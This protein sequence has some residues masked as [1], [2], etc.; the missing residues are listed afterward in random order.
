MSATSNISVQEFIHGLDDIK[1]AE[2]VMKR[3]KEDDDPQTAQYGKKKE[4]H[5]I[6]LS[7]DRACASYRA[8]L[9][10]FLLRTTPWCTFGV[11]RVKSTEKQDLTGDYHHDKEIYK[12]VANDWF[13]T[14]LP[15]VPVERLQVIAKYIAETLVLGQGRLQGVKRFAVSLSLESYNELL[16]QPCLRTVVVTFDRKDNENQVE[17]TGSLYEPKINNKLHGQRFDQKMLDLGKSL[18]HE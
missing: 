11:D 8:K 14:N 12:A 7:W 1:N 17:V 18:V 15:K 2:E 9:V 6:Q 4:R 10:D 5:A 3:F 16:N 13:Q